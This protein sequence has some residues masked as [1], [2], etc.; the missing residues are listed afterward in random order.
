[1][2]PYSLVRPGKGIGRGLF[3]RS[4]EIRVSDPLFLSGPAARAI[5]PLAGLVEAIVPPA[6][7]EQPPDGNGGKNT[8][9]QAGA[10]GDPQGL[11]I[12]RARRKAV[13]AVA[14]MIAFCF[15]WH[16]TASTA[17]PPA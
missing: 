3:V 14:C 13:D 6:L 12:D 2:F 7:F 9:M 5:E 10:A 16:G 15:E 8:E 17:V 11:L 4:L 1:V